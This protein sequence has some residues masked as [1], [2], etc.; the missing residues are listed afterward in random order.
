MLVAQ[1]SLVRRFLAVHR[2]SGADLDDL[3]Q[4]CLLRVWRYRDRVRVQD[5]RRYSIAVARNLAED[6]RFR[7]AKAASIDCRRYLGARP[8]ECDPVDAPLRGRE[9]REAVEGLPQKLRR[10]VE[11]RY[12]CGLAVSDAAALSG[13]T[14]KAF[15]RRLDLARQKLQI[16]LAPSSDFSRGRIRT[17]SLVTS[18]SSARHEVGRL[19]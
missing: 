1:A 11:T 8:E 15:R 14:V 6:H 13:C 2:V 9:V 5:I 10:A 7:C 3:V 16:L 12:F 19:A 17:S 18:R 4:E